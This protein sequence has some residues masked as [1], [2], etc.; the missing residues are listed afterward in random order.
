MF[1]ITLLFLAILFMTSCAINPSAPSDAA[2]AELAPTG[3]LRAGI[4]FQNQ[5]LTSLGP[6]GEQGG[7]A[8]ELVREL[9]KRL[10]VPLEI[11]AYKSAGSLADAVRDRV[12]DVAVL[13]AEPERAKE[14]A[15]APALTE[16]EATYMVPAGSSIKS[17]DEVDRPGIRIVVG[18]NSAYDLYL[19]RTLKNAVRVPIQGSNAA[20]KEF[21]TGQYEVLAGL[22]SQLTEVASS[23]PGMRVLPGN[24]NVV[25]HTAGTPPGREAGSAY[26]S[27][28]V[29]DV[30]ASGLVAQWIA[31]SGI[32]G[33]AAAPAAGQ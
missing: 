6:N 11:T 20:V 28:F 31:K 18:A 15:F 7:V 2:R 22:K 13:G 33:L 32:K 26:L 17:V 3:K 9:A 8:V 16:I 10:N 4:N 19:K 12:W 24:F 23:Q 25:R 1:R 29:E 21:A 5:M 14:I 30:K 27:A